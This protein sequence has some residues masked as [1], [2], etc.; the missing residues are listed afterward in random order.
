MKSLLTVFILIVSLESFATSFG[1][2]SCGQIVEFERDNNKNQMSAISMWFSGY[3]DGRD[4]DDYLNSFPYADPQTLY[5]LLV[6][7]C[8]KEPLLSS[9][10]AAQI[11]YE[12]RK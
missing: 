3:I 10:K 2:F 6:K 12:K 5:L 1:T 9:D 8:R 11:I 4:S 7:E